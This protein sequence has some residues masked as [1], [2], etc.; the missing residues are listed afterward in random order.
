MDTETIVVRVG[1]LLLVALVG[2]IFFFMFRAGTSASGAA[3]VAHAWMD[4]IKTEQYEAAYGQLTSSYRESVGPE[5][6]RE[7]LSRNAY[8]RG[9]QTF[10]VLETESGSNRVRMRG[11]LESVAGPAETTFHLNKESDGGWKISGVV[12]QGQPALPLPGAGT[13]R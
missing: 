2:T 9:M 8:L 7:A 3:E 12:L 13:D 5:T 11:E 6:F 4:Q 1:V 10:K